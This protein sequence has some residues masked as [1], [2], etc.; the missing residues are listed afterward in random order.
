VGDHAD[1]VQDARVHVGAPCRVRWRAGLNPGSTCGAFE[2]FV[3]GRRQWSGIVRLIPLFDMVFYDYAL[4]C[5]N[6]MGRQI[7]TTA[8]AQGRSGCAV[9]NGWSA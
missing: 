2:L 1:G 3:Y 8:V 6:A 7:S 5:T 9:R 4:L